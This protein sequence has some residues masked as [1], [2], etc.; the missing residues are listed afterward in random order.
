[1]HRRDPYGKTRTPGVQHHV[2]PHRHPHRPYLHGHR[3]LAA[4]LPFL[5][6]KPHR[7]DG[8]ACAVGRRLL[9]A[10]C[11]LLW[12]SGRVRPPSHRRDLAQAGA[13]RR[14]EHHR[15]HALHRLHL[16]A[17]RHRLLALA[18]RVLLGHLRDPVMPERAGSHTYPQIHPPLGPRPAQGR[19]RGLGRGGLHVCARHRRTSQHRTGRGGQHR[20]GV[21]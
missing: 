10:L 2:V 5:G 7:H 12:P 11:I 16:R 4:L 6:R 20:R 3:L 1:M 8:R 21:N 13:A 19:H 18:R 14:G 9:T 15:H 17:A